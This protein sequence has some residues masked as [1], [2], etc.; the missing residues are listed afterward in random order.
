MGDVADVNLS[1]WRRRAGNLGMTAQ[2][3]IGIA[4]NQKIPIDRTVRVMTGGA[5]F[6]QGV[7]FEDHGPGLRTVT[8]RATFVQAGHGQA[9]GGFENV[10]AMRIVALHTIHARFKDGMV[11]RQMKLAFDIVVALKTRRGILARIDDESSPATGLDVL[12]AGAMTGFAART[13]GQLVPAGISAGMGT[14]RIDRDNAS[15][16]LRARLVADKM[17]ARYG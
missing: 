2:T 11:L 5:A 16:A 10:A 14:G 3:E 4:L 1:R 6:A 9:A 12:A 7:V 17:G 15:V 13:S 8:L